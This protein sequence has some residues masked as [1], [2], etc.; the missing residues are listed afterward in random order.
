MNI[1]I[2]NIYTYIQIK[3]SD[4]GF[5]TSDQMNRQKFNEIEFL[6]FS[7]GIIDSSKQSVHMYQED[8]SGKNAIDIAFEKN[9]IFSIKLF[10]DSLLQLT[11]ENQFKNCFDK[12]LLPMIMKG[13]DVKWLLPVHSFLM[14]SNLERRSLMEWMKRKKH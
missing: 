10:V 2:R 9:S 12:A 11:N 3:N 1:Q 6:K 13:M 8:I 7:G 5:I 14:S 4:Q